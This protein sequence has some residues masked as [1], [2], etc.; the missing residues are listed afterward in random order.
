MVRSIGM[1]WPSIVTGLLTAAK[2]ASN[3]VTTIVSIDCSLDPAHTPLS[4]Q[5]GEGEGGGGGR[6]G[7]G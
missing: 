1:E 7:L 2:S 3:S 4:I 5:V 6:G